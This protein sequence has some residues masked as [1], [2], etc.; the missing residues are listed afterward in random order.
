M[1]RQTK[2]STSTAT[3]VTVLPSQGCSL[4]C[5]VCNGGEC[6]W[7]TSHG[8]TVC[9]ALPSRRVVA[10]EGS[11]AAH[12]PSGPRSRSA[13]S[14]SR[15]RIHAETCTPRHAHR[16]R[17]A[18]STCGVRLAGAPR[19]GEC[20]RLDGRPHADCF[21]R[22]D[23]A[24]CVLRLR[25]GD[26]SD[27]HA[28]VVGSAP[29]AGCAQV[30]SDARAATGVESVR[31]ALPG[32][33]GAA[34]PSSVSSDGGCATAAAVGAVPCGRAR[35]PAACLRACPPCSELAGAAARTTGLARASLRIEAGAATPLPLERGDGGRI[36]G[37]SPVG[38]AAAWR[39][40]PLA[41]CAWRRPPLVGEDICPVSTIRHALRQFSESRFRA[42]SWRRQPTQR[43]PPHGP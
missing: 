40:R 34:V 38:A 20:A 5:T 41:A 33:A 22:G 37:A 15:F 4:G 7:G 18:A 32:A 28:D 2:N 14:R 3:V 9:V 8:R 11:V 23:E 17:D 36:C 24:C 42:K 43:R 16:E 6:I 13:S 21:E 25:D 31:A 29:F 1:K 27:A 10:P 19:R 30:A 26:H 12:P 35:P 39:A